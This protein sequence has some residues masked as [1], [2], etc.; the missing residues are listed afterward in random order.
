M[1]GSRR[2]GGRSRR[3]NRGFGASRSG[4]GGRRWGSR[5]WACDGGDVGRRLGRNGGGAGRWLGGWEDGSGVDSRD[6]VSGEVGLGVK[7]LRSSL[8]KV[9]LKNGSGQH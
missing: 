8:V 7:I 5:G 9:V 3:R 6:W 2:R 4:V 1:R